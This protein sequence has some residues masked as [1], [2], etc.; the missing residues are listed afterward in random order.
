MSYSIDLRRSVLS[1]IAEGG[2]KSKACKIFKISRPT[3]DR[4]EKKLNDG[5]L[6]D[7]KPKRPWRKIVVDK[8]LTY[9]EQNPNCTLKHYAKLFNVKSSSMCAAFKILKI[10]RKKRPIYTESEMKK[11]V[12]Y[13]WQI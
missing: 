4:W 8:L 7:A 2:S 11:N 9:L 1:Y 13:F 12:E 10:T 5:N 3:L 6:E